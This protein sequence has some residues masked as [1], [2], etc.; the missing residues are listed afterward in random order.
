M[1][2]VLL[3]RFEVGFF[4]GIGGEAVAGPM[5]ATV[6]GLAHAK[7]GC[8]PVKRPL[9]RVLAP[10]RQCL[11]GMS[12]ARAVRGGRRGVLRDV[13][14]KGHASEFG[15]E[16]GAVIAADHPEPARLLAVDMRFS[17]LH[18]PQRRGADENTNDL[19]LQF[20][21]KGMDLLN[22]SQT[23]L[24]DVDILMSNRPGT[25]PRLGTPTEGS[26]DQSAAFMP[27]ITPEVG[28]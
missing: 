17:D 22:P 13:R 15:N 26:A 25:T 4:G 16:L 14:C 27:T 3:S 20:M 2:M 6:R 9:V 19:L 12:G 21:P 18:I 28:I 7:G 10:P 5:E 1:R 11:S 24:C 8:C 23:G